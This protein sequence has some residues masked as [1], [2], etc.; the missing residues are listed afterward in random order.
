MLEHKNKRPWA[1]GFFKQCLETTITDEIPPKEVVLNHVENQ[2]HTLYSWHAI[3]N[4]KRARQNPFPELMI[5]MTKLINLL[6]RMEESCNFEF[7]NTAMRALLSLEE[8]D[9]LIAPLEKRSC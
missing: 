9:E 4:F 7:I 3:Q 2:L 5:Q 1:P 6:N 8:S